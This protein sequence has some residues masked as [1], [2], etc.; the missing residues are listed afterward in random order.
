MGKLS[1]KV[2]KLTFRF[3]NISVRFSDIFLTGEV[4]EWVL[5][6]L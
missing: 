3:I 6:I 5:T 4:L 1:M 2:F